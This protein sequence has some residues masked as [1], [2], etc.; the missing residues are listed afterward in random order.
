MLRDDN[1]FLSEQKEFHVDEDAKK[2]E[3]GV[4]EFDGAEDFYLIPTFVVLARFL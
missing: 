2:V 1:A 4:N 3:S